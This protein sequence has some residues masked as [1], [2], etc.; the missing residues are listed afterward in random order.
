M[1]T[2]LTVNVEHKRIYKYIYILYNIIITVNSQLRE[3]IKIVSCFDTQLKNRW[4][5][6]FQ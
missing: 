5:V 6:S 2:V 4:R 1:S 3:E